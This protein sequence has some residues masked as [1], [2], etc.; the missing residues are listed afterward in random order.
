MS[1]SLLFFLFPFFLGNPVEPTPLPQG[2][3]AAV[4]K[5]IEK[6][7]NAFLRKKNI[8]A[9]SIGIYQDGQVYTQHFGKN[10]QGQAPTNETVYEVGSVTKT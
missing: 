10:G 2:E 7:G 3:D 1:H 5:A 4:I 6:H 9:V 8:R